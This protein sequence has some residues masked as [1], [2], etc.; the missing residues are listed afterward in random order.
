[1]NKKYFEENVIMAIELD[2][3]CGRYWE[4]MA[5]SEVDKY[6]DAHKDEL[7][8]ID[9][10]VT[11]DDP[12]IQKVL[13]TANEIW[14][15]AEKREGFDTLDDVIDSLLVEDESKRIWTEDEIKNLLKNDDR[16]LCRAIL[17]LY[18][19]QTE[20][21]KT[22]GNTKH[23]NGV[24]FNKFDAEIMSSFAEFM[25]RAGFLTEKQIAVA[26]KKMMKYNKQLTRLANA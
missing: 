8:D 14:W 25:Q 9:Y 7:S 18:N 26:R 15:D 5:G 22:I 11:Q 19:E 2:T 3:G 12:E 1:M 20:D 16:F 24:G 10:C 23:S 17:K 6:L 13:E 4:T 21:E